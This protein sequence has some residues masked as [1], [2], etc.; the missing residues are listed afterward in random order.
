MD[1][2]STCVLAWGGCL[3]ET[4]TNKLKSCLDRCLVFLPDQF[5]YDVKTEKSKWYFVCVNACTS[6]KKIKKMSK[7]HDK[8]QKTFLNKKKKKVPLIC[9][10]W[11]TLPKECKLNVI[12]SKQ[13]IKKIFVHFV[14]AMVKSLYESRLCKL[15]KSMKK[16]KRN[17]S[18]MRVLCV[19]CVL[20]I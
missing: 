10:C 16:E 8:S 20:P 4:E 3:D 11:I 5:S 7:R 14:T 19:L 1:S 13:N 12:L 17:D 6:S 9:N 2:G 18:K 15:K